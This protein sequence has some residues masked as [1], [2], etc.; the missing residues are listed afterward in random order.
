MVKIN[1][2]EIILNTITYYVMYIPL[3]IYTQVYVMVHE[4][5]VSGKV[6]SSLWSVVHTS[7]YEER[8]EDGPKRCECNK[9]TIS[10]VKKKKVRVW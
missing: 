6:K 7:W 4:Q 8:R 3:Y 1:H 10:C 5:H 2:T 9:L